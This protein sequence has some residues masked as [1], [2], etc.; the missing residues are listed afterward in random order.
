MGEEGTRWAMRARMRNLR[1]YEDFVVA[2]FKVDRNL[3]FLE[4]VEFHNGFYLS[5]LFEN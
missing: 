1:L 2:Y 3:V 5:V 4:A